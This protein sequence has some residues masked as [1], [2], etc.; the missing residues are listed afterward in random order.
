M[1]PLASASVWCFCPFAPH[2]TGGMP[3]GRLFLVGLVVQLLDDLVVEQ[4]VVA[5][6]GVVVR[7]EVGVDHRGVGHHRVG[8]AL[9]DDASLGLRD[10]FLTDDQ[11]ITLFDS[12][13]RLVDG[14][15]Q[16][17]GEVGIRRVHA[18]RGAKMWERLAK[19]AY[20]DTRRL[21]VSAYTRSHN[22]PVEGGYYTGKVTFEWARKTFPNSLAYFIEHRDGFRTTM[23]LTQIQDFNYAGLRADTNEIV[24]TQ[25]Y[26][27]M[28]G[29]G[30]TTADF[31][32]P[33]CRHIEETVITGKVPYPVERT[34]L[35]SGMTPVSYTH[36]TLPTKRIV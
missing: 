23:I 12:Q 4:V 6:V 17:G 24:S 9:G 13:F 20:A 21:V 27:P 35:T 5:Q 11:N 31:F 15:G 7:T 34:L 18:L 29:H 25:M 14:L 3:S 36:L 28:P 26:L 33:L 16:N 22:L 10:N 19:P 30:S 2:L 32:H 1:H 8:R